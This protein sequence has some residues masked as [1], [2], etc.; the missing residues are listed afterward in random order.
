MSFHSWQDVVI[1]LAN[2]SFSIAL[3]PMLLKT[4]TQV[5][6]T[7]S[8]PTAVALTAMAISFATLTPPLTFSSTL[9]GFNALL[10]F[11]IA[12]WRPVRR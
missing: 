5:P 4:S 11:A 2:I 10:W 9:L 8:I 1:F 12:I 7:S 3:V 6:R